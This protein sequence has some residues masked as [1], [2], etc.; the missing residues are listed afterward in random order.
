MRLPLRGSKDDAEL[1]KKLGLDEHPDDAEFVA[2][3]FGK[4][5][6]LSIVRA[7]AGGDAG[8]VNR[9]G[10]T[11]DDYAFLTLNGKDD[12]WNPK[13]PEGLNITETKI[14]ALQFLTSGAF[15]DS[16]R[17]I[18]AL[19]AASDTNSRI[20]TIGEDLI[21]RTTVSLEDKFVVGKLFDIYITSRPALRTRILMLLSKSKAATEFPD[22]IV[23][24]VHESMQ[25]VVAD[26]PIIQGLEALKLRNAMFN[27]MNWV[28]RMGSPNDLERAAPSIIGFLRAYI[29]EQGWPVPNSRSSDDLTL[30]ALAYETL[31]SMAKTVPSTV[32][33]PGLEL[34]RWLF[35]SLTE[36]KSSDSIFISIEGALASLLNA[37]SGTLDATLRDE[38]R[39]LLLSYM[40][41]EEDDTVVRSAR[42]VTVRWANRC[43]EY[44]D[45]VG[46]WIDILALGGRP[47]ERSDVVEEG[48]KGLVSTAQ[49][50]LKKRQNK[51]QRGAFLT[52]AG[53][54]LVS[55]AQLIG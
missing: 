39:S 31:G 43:L 45:I 50:F 36:E 25:P 20:S 19:F 16:E 6:L 23:Q 51:K 17:F 54:I 27:F 24:I 49:L 1:R 3:W 52:H 14:T 46:R 34:V 42:F 53:S 28:S 13:A 11:A 55:P 18:P 4:L 26:A 38:L 15:N 44:R 41:K 30:R 40:I 47:G 48:N 21:K 22:K 10:L 5:I 7:P 8:P 2:S 37:F 12:A 9:P 35:R 32:L 29:E 33:R